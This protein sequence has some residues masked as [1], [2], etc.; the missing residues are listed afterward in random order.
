MVLPRKRTEEVVEMPNGNRAHCYQDYATLDELKKAADDALDAYDQEPSQQN[1]LTALY[2]T[3]EYSFAAG[4]RE[5]AAD[6]LEDE[7]E[8]ITEIDNTPEVLLVFMDTT[9]LMAEI[10]M[11]LKHLDKALDFAKMVLDIAERH[12]PDTLELIYALELNA[13]IYSLRG[14]KETAKDM[15]TDAIS[16]LQGE[17]SEAQSLLKNMKLS[18]AD[19]EEQ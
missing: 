7:L 2:A 14:E 16:R 17:L 1:Q 15:Y 13:C 18:L 9:S 5:E 4:Q 12:F 10:W 3:T 6:Y 19:L 8:K 11:K